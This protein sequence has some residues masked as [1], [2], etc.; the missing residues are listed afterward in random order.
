MKL[1]KLVYMVLLLMVA[2]FGCQTKESD[3]IRVL[4]TKVWGEALDRTL[5]HL[6]PNWK[7]AERLINE[8]ADVN[9]QDNYGITPLRSA[10]HAD[11]ADLVKLLIAHGGDVN[12]KD[13][14][15]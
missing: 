14:E 7:V 5:L 8:G 1:I 4:P 13:N 15:G 2:V 6:A 9:A 11:S 10:A 12:A 3:S